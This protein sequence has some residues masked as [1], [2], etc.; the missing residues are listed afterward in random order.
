MA[1]RSV[2]V[3][4]VPVTTPDERPGQRGACAFTLVEMLVALAIGVVLWGAVYAALSTAVRI[5]A[6]QAR[7]ERGA[8][9]ARAALDALTRDVIQA[10]ATLTDETAVFSLESLPPHGMSRVRLSTARMDPHDPHPRRHL[11][12]EIAWE[13]RQNDQGLFLVRIATPL[14]R[15][16]PQKAADGARETLRVG[17]LQRFSARALSGGTWSSVWPADEEEAWPCAVQVV[18]QMDDG[19]SLPVKAKIFVPAAM[20]FDKQ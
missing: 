20:R 8:M 14:P 9:A 10:A 13:V 15:L 17:P 11:V 3:P 5:S 12:E 4:S 2:V 19:R 18:L 1:R 6:R 16:K 7:H